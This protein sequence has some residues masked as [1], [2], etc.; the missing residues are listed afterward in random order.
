LASW[1]IRSD[2]DA[3]A[4]RHHFDVAI[5]LA[6]NALVAVLTEHQWLTMLELEDML[7][8]GIAFGE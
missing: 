8:A 3:V 2:R 4:E 6:A 5:G 1:T 7:G